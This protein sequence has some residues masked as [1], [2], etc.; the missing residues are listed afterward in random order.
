[1]S[2][3]CG[4]AQTISP[5]TTR[6][7]MP[8]TIYNRRS[9]LV[10]IRSLSMRKPSHWP[11]GLPSSLVLQRIWIIASVGKNIVQTM[12]TAEGRAHCRKHFL[13]QVLK[14]FDVAPGRIL[15][16]VFWHISFYLQIVGKPAL[17]LT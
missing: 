13:E 12:K 4:L 7:S 16:N 2:E 8:V 9:T 6:D 11:Q 10:R 17:P 14:L 3:H 1:M 5:P 15:I